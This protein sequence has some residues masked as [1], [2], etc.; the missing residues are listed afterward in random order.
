M[1]R[2]DLGSSSPEHSQESVNDQVV[3]HFP[4]EVN[5]QSTQWLNGVLTDLFRDPQIHEVDLDC[6]DVSTNPSVKLGVLLSVAKRAS[7]ARTTLGLLG[8]PPSEIQL[9]HEIAPW[10]EERF[11][12]LDS[13]PEQ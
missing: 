7:G 3:V 13:A 12:I 6:R 5:I 2:A 10:L 11:T 8:I 9:F 1:F 4:C